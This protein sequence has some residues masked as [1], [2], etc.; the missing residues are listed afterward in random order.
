MREDNS[1]FLAVDQGNSFIKLTIFEGDEMKAS[2]SL[3]ASTIEKG[4]D[5]IEQWQPQYGAFCSVGK[6]DSRIVESLRLALDGRL[7]ILSRS[8]RLPIQVAYSTPSTVGLDRLALA[9]GAAYIY[10]GETVAVVDAGTA[11][12]LDVVDST[13]SFRGGRITAG[14][15]LRFEALYH[16]TAALPLVSAEGDLPVIGSSTETSIRSGVVLGMADEIIETFNQYKKTFG[17]GRLV[18]TGGDSHVLADAIGSR[19][20]ADHVPDLMARGLHYIYKYNEI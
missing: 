3:S 17:C 13:P 7:L 20:P 15:R 1:R 5:F 16:H 12:T 10:K 6:I 9:A 2:C 4:F 11:V 14:I 18:L 8:M 19:I